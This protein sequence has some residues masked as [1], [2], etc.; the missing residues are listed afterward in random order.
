[1]VPFVNFASERDSSQADV[2]IIIII[3]IIFKTLCSSTG[4]FICLFL[5]CLMDLLFLCEEEL[6]YDYV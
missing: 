3:I 1:M 4:L 2:I 6:D 5:L